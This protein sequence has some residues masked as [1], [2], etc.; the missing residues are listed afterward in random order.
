M[1]TWANDMARD[2]DKAAA[3]SISGKLAQRGSCNNRA[4]R[5]Y[6]PLVLY[7]YYGIAVVVYKVLPRA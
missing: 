4:S 1:D 7:S 3:T 5:I 6:I 2:M